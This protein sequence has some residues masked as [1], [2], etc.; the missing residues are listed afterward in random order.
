MGGGERAVETDQKV[1]PVSR[2]A[3]DFSRCDRAA[4]ARAVLNDMR[5][6]VHEA[7]TL[8]NSS[9]GEVNR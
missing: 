6:T 5:S 3:G 2:S 7:Q 4:C 1:L 9:C 8:G